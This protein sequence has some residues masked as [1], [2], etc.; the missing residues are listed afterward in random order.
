MQYY[1]KELYLPFAPELDQND[2][3]RAYT[4]EINHRDY[5]AHN[6]PNVSSTPYQTYP[7]YQ[8]IRNPQQQLRHPFITE[9]GSFDYDK[10]IGTMDQAVSVV[11]QLTPI[12]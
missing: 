2:L 5:Y 7:V 9:E 10:A 8:P 4:L 6:H 12:V 3:F 1:P 11:R